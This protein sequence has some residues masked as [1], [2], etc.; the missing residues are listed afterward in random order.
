MWLGQNHGCG[1]QMLM[2]VQK[3]FQGAAISTAVVSERITPACD[4]VLLMTKNET[5]D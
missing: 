1:C 2:S 5:L 4:Y 3:T